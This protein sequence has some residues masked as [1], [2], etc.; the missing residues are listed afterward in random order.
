MKKK[1]IYLFS[2]KITYKTFYKVWKIFPHGD[3][4]PKMII[5][6]KPVWEMIRDK[7]IF[8]YIDLEEKEDPVI[9]SVKLPKRDIL[10]ISDAK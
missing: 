9:F 5:T 2:N 4:V 3:I 6:G 1:S 8:V 7:M 10:I